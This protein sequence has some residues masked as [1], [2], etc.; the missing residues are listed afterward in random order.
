MNVIYPAQRILKRK[1]DKG[2]FQAL[3]NKVTDFFDA[4]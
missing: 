4:K 1:T 3:L 2:N